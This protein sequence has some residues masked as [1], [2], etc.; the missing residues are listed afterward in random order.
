[1]TPAADDSLVTCFYCDALIA[2]NNLEYDHFP[3]P[4]EV[5]GTE[6]VPSCKGCHDMKDRFVLDDWSPSWVVKVQADFPRMSRE[7]RIFLAKLLRLAA[8]R[9]REERGAK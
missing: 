7:T 8:T 9:I 5:G 6:T 1:M 2:K 4:Q 3:A